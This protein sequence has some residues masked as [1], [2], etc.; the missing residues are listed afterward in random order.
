[1]AY[2]FAPLSALYTDEIADL[3]CIIEEMRLSTNA[4]SLMSEFPEYLLPRWPDLLPGRWVQT[5]LIGLWPS[6]Q[7]VEHTDQSIS[8]A[9]RYHIPV[10]TNPGCWSLHGGVWQQLL[11]GVIYMM[12][13]DEPHG[14]VNWG[15][16]VR[17]SVLIDVIAD[18]AQADR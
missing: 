18:A 17:W 2:N 15:A 13:P 3:L 9:I 10:Q 6:Q 16:T 7:I 4:G 11:P 14:A 5:S 12:A 1:M 8:P